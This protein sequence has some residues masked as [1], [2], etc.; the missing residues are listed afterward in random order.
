MTAAAGI[1]FVAAAGVTVA[2]PG[3]MFQTDS[4][5]DWQGAKAFEVA[6]VSKSIWGFVSEACGVAIGNVG[7]T[8]G[9]WLEKVT[10]ADARVEKRS[11]RLRQHATTVA[12]KAVELQANGWFNWCV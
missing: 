9:A 5:Y 4:F 12:M 7:F 8:S 2:A 6:G 11:A 10:Q 1:S 3:G